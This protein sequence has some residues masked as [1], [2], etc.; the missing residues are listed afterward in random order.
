MWLAPRPRC[1]ENSSCARKISGADLDA[2]RLRRD[3]SELPQHRRGGIMRND[4]LLRCLA[5]GLVASFG[6][7]GCS[8]EADITPVPAFPKGTGQNPRGTEAIKYAPGPYG[9]SKGSTVENLDFVGFPNAA[10]DTSGMKIIQMSDFYNP[11]GEDV[12]ADDS[13]YGAGTKKP[14]A[15][16]VVV[17]SVW[18][19]PCNYEAAETLPALYAKYQPMGGEF[20]L[21]LADGTTPGVPAEAKSLYFWTQKYDVDYPSAIDPSSKLASLFEAD[22]FPANIIVR[23][24]DMKII[25]VT[26]GAPPVGSLFWKT[27]EKVMSGAL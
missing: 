25:D 21:A 5:L 24:K 15:L 4:Q 16:L 20:F 18:C 19:G 12:F 9:I 22:A 8:E 1:A 7:L 10:A 13:P 17:S 14:K 23:T 26:S 27:F 11:T 3:N 2:R 6:I